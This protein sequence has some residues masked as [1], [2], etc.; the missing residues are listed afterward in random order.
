MWLAGAVGIFFRREPMIISKDTPE[1]RATT[2]LRALI[3]IGVVSVAACSTPSRTAP[4]SAGGADVYERSTHRLSRVPSEAAACIAEHARTSGRTADTAP[5]YGLE[6]VA[7][8]V[9]TSAAG[10]VLAV[11][12]LTRGR[13]GGS[14]AATTTWTGTV[15]DRAAF[16]RDLVQDC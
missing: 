5:L 4:R 6:S 12:S 10:D 8:T 15:R 13:D 2:L 1:Q 14:V 9:K 11:L 7:V 16:V 3:V